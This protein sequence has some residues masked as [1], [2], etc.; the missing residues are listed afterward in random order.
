MRGL[1]CSLLGN[2]CANT[3]SLEAEDDDE[4]EEVGGAMGGAADRL[5]GS[6]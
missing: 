6:D 5:A 2:N 4:R 1:A 3:G